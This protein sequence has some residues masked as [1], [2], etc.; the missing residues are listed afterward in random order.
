MYEKYP[1]MGKTGS[2]WNFDY[3]DNDI[4]KMNIAVGSMKVAFVA[5]LETLI[6]ARIANNLTGN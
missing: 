4:P 6:S 5:V 1:N 3:V 2:I